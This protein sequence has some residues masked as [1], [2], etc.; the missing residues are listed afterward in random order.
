MDLGSVGTAL[1]RVK[2]GS[3]GSLPDVP[4][5]IAALAEAG[6][7]RPGRPDKLVRILRELRSG[8]NATVINLQ[9]R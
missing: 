5:N 6:A 8:Q 9:L 1:R 4:F 2:V 7:V 3:L